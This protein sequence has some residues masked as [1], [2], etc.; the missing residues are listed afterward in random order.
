MKKSN[1]CFIGIFISLCSLL[2]SS[3]SYA[4]PL[5]FEGVDPFETVSTNAGG[6]YAGIYNLKVGED[7]VAYDSFCI[8]FYQHIYQGT[9]D[10]Y[11]FESLNDVFPSL[12]HPDVADNIAELW[13]DNY[14]KA[15]DNSQIAAGLQIAIWE[16]TIDS[17]HDVS[18]GNFYISSGSNYGAQEMLDKLDGEDFA[19]LMAIT[20]SEY[21]DFVIGNQPVPEPASMM[22]FGTGLIG[23]AAFTRRKLHLKK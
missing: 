3:A 22:L 11:K 1:L 17:D 8:D 15:I 2:V 20:N 9:F 18:N 19:S 16:V 23:L 14:S 4:I 21:Q 6:V 5:S 12:T 10:D 13:F 7:A